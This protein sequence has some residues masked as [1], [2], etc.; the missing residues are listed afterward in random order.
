LDT[1]QLKRVFAVLLYGLGSYMA[2]RVL[3]EP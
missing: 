1:Q 2:W 3:S